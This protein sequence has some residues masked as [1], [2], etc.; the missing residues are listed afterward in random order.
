MAQRLARELG[1]YDKIEGQKTFGGTRV[2]FVLTRANGT[3]LL[4]ET[5]NAVSCDA[6]FCVI[7]PR[8]VQQHTKSTCCVSAFRPPPKSKSL[9]PS[10]NITS[11]LAFCL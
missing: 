10:M 11:K 4:V 3:K 7:L 8:C 2:D 9:G 1:E 6:F 5:K